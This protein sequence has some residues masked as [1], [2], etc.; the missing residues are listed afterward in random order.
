MDNTKIALIISF[1]LPGLGIVYLGN[2]KRG[3]TIFAI[4]A[5]LR[6]LKVFVLGFLALLSV[7]LSGLMGFTLH[8]WKLNLLI[9]QIKHVLMIEPLRLKEAGDS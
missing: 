9:R 3:L 6:I 8:M 7:L 5:I 4:F 1:L 2:T